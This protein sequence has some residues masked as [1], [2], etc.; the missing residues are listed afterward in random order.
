MTIG[1]IMDPK[2]QVR[3]SYNRVAA[4]Y[5]SSPMNIPTALA[6]PALPYGS[7]SNDFAVGGPRIYQVSTSGKASLRM[8]TSI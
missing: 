8:I 3:E 2:A 5:L 4:A 1:R 6:A 7:L